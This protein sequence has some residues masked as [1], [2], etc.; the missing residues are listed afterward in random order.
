MLDEEA[1]ST[2]SSSP[3]PVSL[4]RARRE[5]LKYGR[6]FDDDKADAMLS[7]ATN[8]V[9]LAF[10]KKKKKRRKNGEEEE[11]D[12]ELLAMG[13]AETDEATVAMFDHVLVDGTKCDESS[14]FAKRLRAFVVMRA[15]V[16]LI[17][18][19]GIFDIG[20]RAKTREEVDFYRTCEFDFEK[21]GGKYMRFEH[22]EMLQI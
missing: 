4:R 11:Y 21:G 7:G 18:E 19:K 6:G 2:S 13:V 15:V 3:S 9:V 14:N 22:K 20:V 1:S 8:V 10:G 16:H 5:L 12:R 17:N